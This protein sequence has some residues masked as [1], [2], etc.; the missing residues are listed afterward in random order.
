VREIFRTRAKIT[1]ALRRWLDDR[2]FIEV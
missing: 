2:G 1:T